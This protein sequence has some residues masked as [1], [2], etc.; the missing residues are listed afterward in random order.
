MKAHFMS[1][2]SERCQNF[3]GLTEH[4]FVGLLTSPL[5]RVTCVT[6][7]TDH[8][9]HPALK[10][11]NVVLLWSHG[12]YFTF[13]EIALLTV[14]FLLSTNLISFRSQACGFMLIS[15]AAGVVLIK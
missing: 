9:V 2:S 13:P 5:V 12:L 11:Q 4:I 8:L 10:A 1:Q 15:Q 7:Q 14:Q 6:M 3:P